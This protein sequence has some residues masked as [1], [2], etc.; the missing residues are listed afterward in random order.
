M[1]TLQLFIVCILIV[2]TTKILTAQQIKNTVKDT[3]FTTKPVTITA[4]RTTQQ[5]LTVPLAVSIVPQIDLQ[6]KRGYGLDEVLSN[7]PGVLVQARTGNQDVRITIRGYGARGAGERSNAGTSRGIRVVVDG[8]PQTEPDGRTA[9]D[10]IDIAG[11]SSI[12]V[13]RSNASALWGNASGGVVNISSV[14]NTNKPFISMQTQ[15]GSFGFVKNSLQAGT[16]TELGKL[17]LSF[18]NTTY[19]GWREH[20][21]SALS[22]FNVGLL[23]KVNERTKLGVFMS[24]ASN[25]F[26]VSGPLTQAQYDS[27]AQQ[28]QT[29]DPNFIARDERRFNRLGQIGVTLDHEIDD[30]NSITSMTFIQPKF[31]QRSER[32]TFREFTRYHIGGNLMYK[33]FSVIT[34][35]IS[36]QFLMGIDEQYQDGAI[37]FYGLKEGQRDTVLQQDKR[38]GANNLGLFVQ[39]EVSFNNLSLTVGGRYDKISYYNEIYFDGG[40]KNDI[41]EKIYNKVTPKLGLL[42]RLTPEMSIYANLGGGIEIP[43]GNEVDPPGALSSSIIN[44]LLEPMISSTYEIGWKAIPTIS[45]FI[46]LGSATLSLDVATYLINVSNEIIPYNGGRY[47]ISAGKTQRFGAEFGGNVSMENGFSITSAFTLCKSKYVEYNL[48]SLYS[49]SRD[50]I[51]GQAA[52]KDYS[53]NNIAG[54]PDYY[55]TVRAKWQPSFWNRLTV[56][57]EMRTVGR[58][59]ADNANQLT[60][61]SYTT[62]DAG[63]SYEQ[64]ISSVISLRGFTRVMNITNQKYITSAWINPERKI[65]IN[66]SF[67]EAGLPVNYNA[68]INLSLKID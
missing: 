2:F 29:I 5:I 48:S 63:I 32:S 45:D 47:Y 42:Y 54:M 3:T 21:E 13:L 38:E 59:F 49:S 11:A 19:D 4:S 18:N 23:S 16:T 14:P 35:E 15:F 40:N 37:L 68:G 50:T 67:L 26:R 6:N 10:L 64:P 24:A 52:Y 65:G 39:E 56:D 44:P 34:N 61:N 22:Q 36:S 1:K 12:E 7:I 41:T 30:N 17:Y 46:G 20:S 31:L 28:A 57:A 66:P 43:A 8:I 25:I 33:N 58:Y 53:Q 62:I 60:V 51:D 27:N 9:F 55:L